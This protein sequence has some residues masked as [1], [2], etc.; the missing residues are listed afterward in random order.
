MGDPHRA[1]AATRSRG[2][3]CLPTG[4]PLLPLLLL[5]LLLPASTPLPAQ[6][7][8]NPERLVTADDA[9]DPVIRAFQIGSV[10][11]GHVSNGAVRFQI[12]PL[13]ESPAIELVTPGAVSS[14]Q[15]SISSGGPA[16]LLFAQEDVPGPGSGIHESEGLAGS[17]GPVI[18]VA[19]SPQID[20]APS[21]ANRSGFG[22]P[23][24]VWV[25]EDAGTPLILHLS[26]SS[27]LVT[28]G[29]GEAPHL[30]AGSGGDHE[31]V[32][33]RGGEV[34]HRSLSSGSWSAETT[35]SSPGGGVAS[36]PRVAVDGNGGI[37]V[38]HLRGGAVLYSHRPVGGT[39]FS[40]P[41]SVSPGIPDVEQALLLADPG[42]G[43]VQLFFTALGDV[44]RRLG[45][46]GLLFPYENLTATP[47][48][49]EDRLAAA[50]DPAGHAHLV[51]RRAGS[52]WY[53]NEVPAPTADF[54]LDP[55]GGSLPLPVQFTSLS[56]GAIIRHEW[57]FGDG[58]TS[59]EVSPL[60]TYT[61]AGIYD[62]T[63]TVLGPGGNDTMTVTEAVEVIDT[64]S[65][66]RVPDLLVHRGEPGIVVPVLLDNA[67]PVMGYQL[68]LRW[69]PAVLQLN[70]ADLDQTPAGSLTPDFLVI[71]SVSG[72]SG[73]EAAT[74]GVLFDLYPPADGR[75]LPPG[76]DQRI[77][78][79]RFDVSATAPTA[80]PTAIEFD[81]TISSPP[82]A[83]SITV[84][85]FS[86]SPALSDGVV[87]VLP[88]GPPPPLRFLR[89][90]FDMGGGLQLNDAVS[91]LAFLFTGGPAPSCADAADLDDNGLLTISDPIYL[92]SF[93]FAGG[94]APPYPWPG[95]GLDPTADS[96]PDC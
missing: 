75:V 21:V 87:T 18:E 14:P 26:P 45:A 36:A 79:L 92:L 73:P 24:V 83:V 67:A 94:P 53:R 70:S 27:G 72:P 62:V 23:D 7:T 60:H 57:D 93:L 56:A 89:G 44:W 74:V 16:R 35:L 25:R 54:T 15:I 76:E 43:G 91:I 68:G 78:H 32:Y 61:K 47:A 48:D 8:L 28:V 3:C 90:D 84:N 86:Q 55:G 52:L 95:V 34:R 51:Y 13:L 49:P 80:A 50:V 58:S 88:D 40:T 71:N 5:L 22:S 37:H 20:R 6:L 31:L 4:T 2:S 81:E 59:T 30:A 19:P 69:D 64:S 82:I 29:E 38:V 77:L 33:L 1:P 10:F 46:A 41:I 65:A 11:I 63:L 96:F 39:A 17:F 42:L 66:M 9:V 12:G 85:G